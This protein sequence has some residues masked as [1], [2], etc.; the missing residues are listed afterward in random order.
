[1]K[2]IIGLG[3]PGP[4][5]GRTRHNVGFWAIDALAEKFH[6]SVTRSKFQS[7]VGDARIGEEPVLLVKPQT[8]MNLSGAAVADVVNFYK[9]N[10]ATDIFVIYDD[11]DFQPG[12]LKLRARGSAG[13]HNGIKSIIASLG[14]EAFC[15]VR[16]GIGRPLPEAVLGHVLGT[17]SKEDQARVEKA[18]AAAAE[19]S[20][21]A[22]LHGFERAMNQY[23]QVSF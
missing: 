8:F 1:M 20:E 9:L 7:L 18:V 10:A 14:T 3:N 22:C 19:A 23:N 13:G 11:M 4:K 2:A 16:I 12:Q 17:F 21:Y 6:T 5:Y 15:R